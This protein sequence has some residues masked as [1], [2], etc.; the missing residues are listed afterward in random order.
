MGTK[1]RFMGALSP[2]ADAVIYQIHD[3]QSK[4]DKARFVGC[5]GFYSGCSVRLRAANVNKTKW[6]LRKKKENAKYNQLFP[7]AEQS[8]KDG[9]MIIQ[10]AGNGGPGIV[11]ILTEAGK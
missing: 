9:L 6:E 5:S 2:A 10:Y 11:V 1:P 8:R 7:N 3:S 4:R